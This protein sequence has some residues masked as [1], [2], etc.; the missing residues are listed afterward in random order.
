MSTANGFIA[1]PFKRYTAFFVDAI[2]VLLIFAMVVV[3]GAAAERDLQRWDVFAIVYALYQGGMVAHHADQTF[4]RYLTGVTVMTRDGGR[5][6]AAQSYYRAMIRAMPLALVESDVFPGEWTFGAWAILMSIEYH[7][8]ASAPQ[9]RTLADVLA[10]TL[11][12]N[13]PPP[14]THRAPA[15]PMFSKDDREFG[16]PPKGPPRNDGR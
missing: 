16:V 1:P 9:R 15:G 10:Q 6:L 4:G 5:L 13:L 2:V 14:H 11:V 3:L 7:R 12:I 8:I